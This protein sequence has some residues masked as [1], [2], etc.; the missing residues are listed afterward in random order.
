MGEEMSQ[1]FRDIFSDPAAAAAV[2]GADT[3]HPA[4]AD[5]MARLAAY[6]HSSGIM[7]GV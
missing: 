3:S 4:Y 2:F 5:F 1:H 6:Q 7:T